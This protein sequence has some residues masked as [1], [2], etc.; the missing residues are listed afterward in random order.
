MRSVGKVALPIVEGGSL[1][2]K[3]QQVSSPNARW[4]VLSRGPLPTVYW[5]LTQGL[6]RAATR[7]LLQALIAQGREVTK[8]RCLWRLLLASSA[9]AVGAQSAESAALPIGCCW[10]LHRQIQNLSYGCYPTAAARSSPKSKTVQATPRCLLA[11]A[12]KLVQ[13]EE[14]PRDAALPARLLLATKASSSWLIT[15]RRCTACTAA[16]A[17]VWSAQGL[18]QNEAIYLGSGHLRQCAAGLALRST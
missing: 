11:A 14:S 1:A 8:P 13:H 6:C 3:V 5:S 4:S 2:R 18:L 17:T 12:G 10:L 7:R 16:S 15:K 9:L